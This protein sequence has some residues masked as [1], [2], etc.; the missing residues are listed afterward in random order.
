[1]LCNVLYEQNK[2]TSVKVH[3]KGTTIYLLMF[4]IIIRI[5]INVIACICY[6]ALFF[7]DS[8]SLFVSSDILS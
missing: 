5:F 6:L 7:L 2:A 8:F 4:L 1:M 3:S